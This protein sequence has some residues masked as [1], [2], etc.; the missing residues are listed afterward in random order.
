MVGM[1]R[2]ALLLLLTLAT[3][4]VA[5]CGPP[6]LNASNHELGRK[7]CS[8]NADCASGFCRNGVCG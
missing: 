8:A 1:R 3:G 5:S 7:H 4:T 6:R 2:C